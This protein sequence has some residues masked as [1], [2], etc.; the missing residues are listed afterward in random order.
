ML[1]PDEFSSP[2]LPSHFSPRR[3]CLLCPC[4]QSHSAAPGSCLP[5]SFLLTRFVA[6]GSYSLFPCA[7]SRF[8][9]RRFCL[10][11]SFLL[12]CFVARGFCLPI[13]SLPPRFVARGFVCFP[14]SRNFASSLRGDCCP[15]LHC[16]LTSRLG[17]HY[18]SV[19]L[20][21]ISVC[22]PPVNVSNEG[23]PKNLLHQRIG[24]VDS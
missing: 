3:S 20:P 1:R 12:P 5:T 14:L 7:Q 23:R 6:R 18:Y 9:A 10:S 24:G 19:E 4:A 13:S 21:R 11:T 16:H 8:V 2:S 17:G 15:A 22:Q